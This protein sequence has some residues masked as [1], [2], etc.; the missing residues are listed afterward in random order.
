MIKRQVY[1]KNNSTI[2]EY[3]IDVLLSRLCDLL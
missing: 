3:D 1:K 2:V